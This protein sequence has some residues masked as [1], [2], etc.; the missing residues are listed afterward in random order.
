MKKVHKKFKHLLLISPDKVI[1]P[2]YKHGLFVPI[3]T[4]IWPDD[5]TIF[6]LQLLL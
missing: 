3:V 4:N 6:L 1:T 2:E 5:F